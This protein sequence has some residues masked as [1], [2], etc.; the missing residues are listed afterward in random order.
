MAETL[1]TCRECGEQYYNSKDKPGMIYHCWDCGSKSETT[2]R[3]GGNMI[4]TSKQAPE[5]E[6]KPINEA[7]KF[8]AKVRRLGGGV[9]A[10]L[11]TNK[12]LAEKSLF[13]NGTWVSDDSLRGD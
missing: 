9:T 1:I 11:V 6:I 4:Y 7:K 8:N 12:T 2:S 13:K 5:I 10:S 3:V